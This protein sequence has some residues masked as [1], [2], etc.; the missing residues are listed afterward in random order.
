M[1]FVREGEFMMCD[2]WFCK[3]EEETGEKRQGDEVFYSPLGWTSHV[4]TP[5]QLSRSLL[6][7]SIP[8]I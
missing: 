4:S 1:V 7:L 5:A 6:Q 2:G 3:W 8:S